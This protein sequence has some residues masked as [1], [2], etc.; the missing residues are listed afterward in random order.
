MRKRHRLALAAASSATAALTTLI[1]FVR[2]DVP[3]E[4]LRYEEMVVQLADAC[5][6]AIE[7]QGGPATSEENQLYGALEKFLEG[8]A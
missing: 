6:L 2:H 8:W 3:A 7:A 4:H 1:E 5:R